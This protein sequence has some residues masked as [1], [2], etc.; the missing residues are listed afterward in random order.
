MHLA[1]VSPLDNLH[2]GHLSTL[3]R[4]VPV[5]NERW[6]SGLTDIFSV[7]QNKRLTFGA[8]PQLTITVL[9]VNGNKL[10]FDYLKATLHIRNG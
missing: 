2:N 10:S 1:E 6:G 4:S 8:K 5:E 9:D 7:L 3:L